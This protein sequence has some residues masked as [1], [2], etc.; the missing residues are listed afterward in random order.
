MRCLVRCPTFPG[1]N[2]STAH[3]QLQRLSSL[4]STRHQ[5][6]LMIFADR[7][8]SA[9]C[10]AGRT[11]FRGRNTKPSAR[12]H[13]SSSTFRGES[14]CR[15]CPRAV[16]RFPVP[17]LALFWCSQYKQTRP[18]GQVRLSFFYRARG[19][20]SVGG[21]LELKNQHCYCRAYQYPQRLKEL[22]V[23]SWRAV[24]YPKPY[25]TLS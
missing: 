20:V 17:L 1:V 10:T 9:L 12:V 14:S 15:L 8:Y 25:S 7:P 6:P 16:V 4:Q 23:V 13:W 5:N 2:P 19:S 24:Q 22:G 18:C 3:G 11:S 21:R